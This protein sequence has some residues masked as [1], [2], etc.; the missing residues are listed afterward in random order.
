MNEKNTTTRGSGRSTNWATIVYPESAIANWKETL[1]DLHLDVLISP[2][3][4]RDVNPTGE[5]KKAHYHVLF[6]FP[7][8][9]TQNQV[10]EITDTIGS[11]GVERI[12][13]FRNYARYLCHLDNPDKARY[14]ENDVI[15]FGALS[16]F[17]I[18]AVPDDKYQVIGEMIDFCELNKI[19]SYAQLL[20]I[21]RKYKQS[22]YR[23]LCD[24]ASWVMKEYL[25]ASMWE[26]SNTS[27]I[28]DETRLINPATGEILE[29][30][31]LSKK[32]DV[33]EEKS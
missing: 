33:S 29:D 25:K 28:V 21:T 10:K 16:Y 11:V 24:N 31:Q 26:R 9:Q 32:E 22:W 12:A 18:I 2:L 13:S 4:N 5:P 19:V 3:H 7:S 1:D 23:A 20:R 27:I 8:V 15:A 30:D 6:R 14:D 17:D